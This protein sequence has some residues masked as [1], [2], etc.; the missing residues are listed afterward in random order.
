[1]A[2]ASSEIPSAD[3]VVTLL[4]TSIYSPS[5][6]APLES[7]LNGQISNERPYNFE[8]NR[9]L[10]KLYQFYPQ[11]S[12]WSNTEE[13]TSYIL[14]LA[15][16]QYPNPTDIIA[17]SCLVPEK[18]QKVEPIA[19]ILRCAD[20][21]DDC[22]FNEFWELFNS[23]ISTKLKN[24]K[25]GNASATLHLQKSILEVLALSYRVAPISVV[26]HALNIV[27]DLKTT[28]DRFPDNIVSFDDQH[29]TFRST[30]DNTKRNRVYQDV[31]FSSI[32]SLMTKIAR[33]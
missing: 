31:D 5:K 23:S 20:L 2:A 24:M 27:G 9:T 18:I 21:L 11:N 15:L 4:K 17:L 14:M 32:T 7:Y 19:S 16:L 3:E 6:Q 1:M 25:V 10:L 13:K 30:T 26:T 28:L 33:D 8:A 22:Q 29:L 12:S